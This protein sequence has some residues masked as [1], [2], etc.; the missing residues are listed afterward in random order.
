[1]RKTTRLYL[2]LTAAALAALPL[3][4]TSAHAVRGDIYET[5]LDMVLRIRPGGGTPIT[6]ADGLVN[7]KGLVFDGNGRLF[8]ADA[9][10][11]TIMIYTLPDGAGSPYAQASIPRWPS[12]LIP[13]AIYSSERP[14]AATSLNSR[15]TG[16][17]STFATGVGEPAGFA[18][19][20]NGNLF[21]SDFDGRPHYP[22]HS[23]GNED[24]VCDRTR[25]AGGPGLR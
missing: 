6:F 2:L 22:N 25:F 14:G 23:R 19:A 9:G 7:P 16:A 18:F 10:A 20:T 21:V 8:V 11:G 1:M 15:Q 13:R 3:I 17:R 12:R 5:N 4:A 24:H